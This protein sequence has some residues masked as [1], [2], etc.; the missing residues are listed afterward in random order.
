MEPKPNYCT[1]TLIFVQSSGMAKSRFADSFGKYCPM[2]NF[3][4]C[5]K[6]IVGY[7]LA[8]GEIRSF[9]CMSLSEADK[10]RIT[11]SPRV[12][13]VSSRRIREEDVRM[14]TVSPA[15]KKVQVG[16]TRST[17]TRGASFGE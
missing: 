15:S 5:E 10:K 3:I 11:D 6:G 4:R 2:I 9:M 7:P 12:N 1:E 17:A 16:Y 13:K 8:D 14:A